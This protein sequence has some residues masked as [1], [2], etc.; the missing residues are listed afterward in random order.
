MVVVAGDGNAQLVSPIEH[1]QRHAVHT[2]ADSV[3]P[4]VSNELQQANN[5]RMM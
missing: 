5:V 4:R 2:K 1:P 3:I